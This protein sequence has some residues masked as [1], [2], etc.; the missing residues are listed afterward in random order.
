MLLSRFITKFPNEYIIFLLDLQNK[1]GK[2]EIVCL[3]A[4]TENIV[5]ISRACFERP[6]NVMQES[7][8]NRF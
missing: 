8:P 3:K 1:S 6:L 2:M 7:C 5:F 4:Y